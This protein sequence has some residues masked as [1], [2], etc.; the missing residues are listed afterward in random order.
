MFKAILIIMLFSL[1]SLIGYMYG[2]K[3]KKRCDSL[4]ECYKSITLLQNEVVYNSTPL[5]EA[6]N[7]IGKKISE[8]FSEILINVGKRLEEGIEKNVY[9]AFFNEYTLCEEDIYLNKED[10]H[11]LGDFLKSL[12]ESGVYGQDKIFTLA[13]ENMKINIKDADEISKKNTKLYRYLGIC[14]GAMISIFL[15]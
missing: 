1:C 11:I 10:K 4:R 7:Q 9:S 12:G 13:L 6:F 14:F 2:D 3:F 8:P 5:P 15:L